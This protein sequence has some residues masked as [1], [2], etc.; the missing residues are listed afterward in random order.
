MRVYFNTVELNVRGTVRFSRYMSREG[1]G[2]KEGR[3]E[4]E[5][6]KKGGYEF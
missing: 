3:K 1:K 5:K 6:R 4:G 2:S